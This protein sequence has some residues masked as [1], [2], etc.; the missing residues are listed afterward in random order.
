MHTTPTAPVFHVGRAT[1]GTYRVMYGTQ[2]ISNHGR[3]KVEAEK[4]ASRLAALELEDNAEVA[5]TLF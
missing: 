4:K 5:D 2:L 1:D 3:R